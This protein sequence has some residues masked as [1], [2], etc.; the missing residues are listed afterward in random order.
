M[1]SSLAENLRKTYDRAWLVFQVFHR[2]VYGTLGVMPITPEKVAIFV[3]YMD[4]VGHVRTTIRTYISTLSHE[5][6]LEDEDDPTAKFCI[7]APEVSDQ[8][9]WKF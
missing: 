4:S 9:R 5:H 2:G 1:D 6:K 8:S 3:A 7:R